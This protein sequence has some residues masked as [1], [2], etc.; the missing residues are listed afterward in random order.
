LSL[1]LALFDSLG[2]FAKRLYPG[3]V[4]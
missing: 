3:I 4:L 1:C 2:M